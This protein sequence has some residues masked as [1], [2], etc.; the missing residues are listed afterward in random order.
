MGE[1]TLIKRGGSGVINIKTSER[2]GDVVGVK[3]VKEGD[4][5]LIVTKKGQMIRVPVK[6]ISVIGRATQG[7]RVMSLDEGDKITTITRVLAK[8]EE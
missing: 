2:N 5:I 7:V 4:E 3:T 1:Y 8:S 6:A